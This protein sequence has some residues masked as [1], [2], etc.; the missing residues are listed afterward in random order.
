[1]R[2]A[3]DYHVHGRSPD[4]RGLPII[5]ADGATAGVVVDLWVDE[6]E[7]TLRYLEVE[8]AL[9]VEPDELRRRVLVP[10]PFVRFRRH[11][12]QVSVR[13][14]LAAQ[15]RDIPRLRNPEQV[16]SLEEDKL[17][18]YFGGGSLYATPGRLGPLL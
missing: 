18:A 12:R 7:E 5:G 15:F 11:T 13:A 2:H 1:M 4:P 3:P 8:L 16:T 10:Q 6:I 9:D 17:V 14:L